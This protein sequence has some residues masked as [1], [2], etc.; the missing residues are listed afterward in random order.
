MTQRI[1]KDANYLRGLIEYAKKNLQKGYARD[2]LKWALVNQG[3]SKMEVEKA[4]AQASS[5]YEKERIRQ[6]ISSPTAVP[7]LSQAIEVEPEQPQSF[8]KRIFG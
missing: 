3:H 5:E 4:L 1:K 6:P 8:W 2:S 7:L